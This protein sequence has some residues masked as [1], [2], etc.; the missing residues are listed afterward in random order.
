MIGAGAGISVIAQKRHIQRSLDKQASLITQAERVAGGL[1]LTIPVSYYA[2]SFPEQ[3]ARQGIPIS[4]SENFLR[5]HPALIALGASMLGA[6][7][8]RSLGKRI[9]IKI[10]KKASQMLSQLDEKS[11]NIVYKD[12]IIN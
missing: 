3:K 1:L 7:G 11:L 6:A 12:L 2:A 9:Q 5:K 4:M 10:V 8:I